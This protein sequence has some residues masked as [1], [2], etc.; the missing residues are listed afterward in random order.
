MSTNYQIALP[1]QQPTP[2]NTTTYEFPSKQKRPL[3]V[4]GRLLTETD[5]SGNFKG[6]IAEYY[7]VFRLM[8]KGIRVYC[9]TGCDGKTDL[10]IEYENNYYP[11]DVKL[12]TWC[13]GGKGNYCWDCPSARYVEAPVTALI[14]VPATGEDSSGW[15]CKWRRL[16]TGDEVAP[17]GLENLWD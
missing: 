9:N 6:D 7:A 17:P 16:N 8:L 5:W 11:F 13:R 14:V 15:Y 12:A 10:L 2:E 1:L 3:G 4:V